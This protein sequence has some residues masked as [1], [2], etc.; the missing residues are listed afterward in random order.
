M[1]NV[2]VVMHAFLLAV[3]AMV[4]GGCTSAAKAADPMV[5]SQASKDMR[6]PQKKLRLRRELGGR[7]QV[8]GCGKS[9]VYHS[10]CQG[11]SCQVGREGEIPQTWRG[12]P[13]PGTLESL[14]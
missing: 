6:C 4:L 13:E 9:A 8:T 7:Y 1:V 11:L 12:R 10:A 3:I 14:R 5:R 2:A